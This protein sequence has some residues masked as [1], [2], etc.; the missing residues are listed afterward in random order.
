MNYSTRRTVGITDPK[1]P[2]VFEDVTDNTAIRAFKHRS[3]SPE[4]NYIFETT[5]GGVAIFDYDRD[6]L[7]DVY[8]VNGSTTGRARWQRKGAS[9][10]ALP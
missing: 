2:V 10:S 8:L 1:A 6:G 7:P 3:G 5:S 4:K 9:L